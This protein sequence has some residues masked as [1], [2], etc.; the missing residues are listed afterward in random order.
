VF[1]IIFISYNEPNANDNWKSLVSRFPYARRIN[2]VK[3]IH[4]AH[5]TSAKLFGITE[6]FWVVDGDT[7]I[8]ESFTFTPPHDLWDDAVY[9]YRARNPVN[10]LVYG[11]GGL[12]LLP[13]IKT[14]NMNIDNTDMSTSIS[15]N[16]FIIDEVASTT[17]FNTD[18]FNTW[19]S[20]FRECVKLSSKIINNQIDIETEERLN[21]WCTLGQDQPYGEWCIKGARAGKEYGSS[22]TANIEAIKK[23][24][25][26]NWLTEYFNCL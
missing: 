25:D 26:F 23:I 8:E 15:E 16:F 9:V 14:A 10:N 18:P 2:G 12:K 6:K 7:Q 17:C 19:K 5:K 4:Q 11:Y 21:A 24:N 22:N 13:K 3:G 20:A 1:D